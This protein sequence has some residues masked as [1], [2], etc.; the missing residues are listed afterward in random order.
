M[1]CCTNWNPKPKSITTAFEDAKHA[2]RRTGKAVTSIEWR[3]QWLLCGTPELADDCYLP[4][5]SAFVIISANPKYL[6]FG[7]PC[8]PWGSAL[9]GMTTKWDVIP[10]EKW[11]MDASVMGLRMQSGDPGFK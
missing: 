3:S 11:R 7:S 5:A 1:R 2:G 8:N 10:C 4:P 6:P 9:R